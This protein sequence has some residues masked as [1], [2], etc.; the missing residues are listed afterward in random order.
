MDQERP[1]FPFFSNFLTNSVALVFFLVQGNS[2]TFGCGLRTTLNK[3]QGT[4]WRLGGRS[5]TQLQPPSALLGLG[6]TARPGLGYCA[7]H[8]A[9]AA[10]RSGRGPWAA[11]RAL[12]SCGAGVS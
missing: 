1:C 2:K 12:G 6:A 4:G 3:N 10:P 9:P 7:R 8:A 11:G 5:R